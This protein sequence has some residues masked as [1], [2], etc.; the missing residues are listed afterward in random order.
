MFNIHE[1]CLTFCVPYI[2][3]GKFCDMLQI[4]EVITYEISLGH[5]LYTDIQY[6]KEQEFVW[7]I[8]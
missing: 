2:H 8:C 1:Y 6:H 5:S 3:M 4:S 7:D